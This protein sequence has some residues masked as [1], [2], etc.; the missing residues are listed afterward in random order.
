LEIEVLFSSFTIF[1]YLIWRKA[2]GIEPTTYA[3]KPIKKQER[4]VK[5][6][7]MQF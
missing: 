1:K 4:I 2:C 5:K 6:I 7:K 3:D